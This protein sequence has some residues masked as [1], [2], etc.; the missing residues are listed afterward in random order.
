MKTSARKILCIALCVSGI[1]AT[2]NGCVDSAG[3]QSQVAAV[4][5]S[6]Y[7]SE[8]LTGTGNWPQLNWV[9]QFNDSQL[10][11][12]VAEAIAHNPDMQIAQT[13]VRAALARSEEFGSARGFTG[14]VNAETGRARLPTAAEPFNAKVGNSNVPVDVSFNPWISPTSLLISANYD[15]DLW[16]EKSSLLRALK[17]EQSAV[18]VETEQARLTLTTTLV[19]L[20]FQLDYY[21]SIADLIEEQ[22]RIYD[23][24][25]NVAQARVR[26]GLDGEYDRSEMQLKRSALITQ[27]L[28]NEQNITQTQLQLGLLSGAGAERGF[29]LRRPQLSNTADPVLPAQLAANLLGRRPDVVAARLRVEALREKTESTKAEF[30][31][32]VNL[33]ALAGFLTTDIASLFSSDAVTGFVGPAV[34]LPIFDRGRIRARLKGDYAN[35][36]IA[37]SLYN[38]AVNEAF[39]DIVQ[40]LTA[41]SS[42]DSIIEQQTSAE[43][44]A[45]RITEI[46]VKRHDLG[47]GNM[48]NTLLAKLAQITET[49]R[50]IAL[51]AQRRALQVEMVRALGGGFEATSH[52]AKLSQTEPSQAA[53]SDKSVP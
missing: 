36:D 51:R 1:A 15:F 25:E 3:I 7:A 53:S 2:L 16:G 34:S 41:I 10:D 38:K 5:P 40:Q 24:I 33:S 11:E 43:K 48:K 12:L 8:R 14:R 45:N 37:V 17:L 30:Y 46:A 28:L 26:Q 19:K 18:M 50:L 6:Q 35:L 20:Y 13:R 9:T 47:I 22:I 49:Q 31:P 4:E 29:T 32:D 27:Q 44:A 21:L 39:G 23:K 52:I 42:T